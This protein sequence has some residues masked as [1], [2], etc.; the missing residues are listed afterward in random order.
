MTQPTTPTA[1]PSGG[2]SSAVVKVLLI[3]FA[4]VILF[5]LA[6]LGSC[7]YLGYRAKKKADEIR[8][9]YKSGDLERIAGA[10]GVGPAKDSSASSTSHSAKLAFPAWTPSA[11]SA[12][13]KVPL[14]AGLTAVSAVAQFGGDYQSVLR[15][16]KV[17]PDSV[18]LSLRADNVPNPL[19]GL[20]KIAGDKAPPE[21]GSVSAQRTVRREDMRTAHELQEWFS[22]N[23]PDVFPGTTAFS[24]SQEVFAELRS[25]GESSFRFGLGGVKGMVGSLVG[26]LEQMT[27]SADPKE[28]AASMGKANCTLK[29]AGEVAFPILLNDRRVSL[30]AMH[31]Q[32]TTEDGTADFYFLDDPENPLNLAFKLGDNGDAVQVISMSYPRV[33]AEEAGAGP[34]PAQI[35]QAP[36]AAD[37]GGEGGGPAGAG[38]DIEKEL[39]Q[40]GQAEVYGIYFD[41][42]SDKMKPE[43]ETVLK[44]IAAALE[45][46]ASWN[47]RVEGHTDN[48]GGDTYNMDLSQRRAAAVK[49]AL[50]TRHGIGESRLDPQ[51]FGATRPKESNDTVAGRARNR[52]VELVRK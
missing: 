6:V 39:A 40:N 48:V 47:L 7:V 49:Q 12:Q 16:N 10:V 30:P 44:E 14:V 15:I 5:M 2:G 34:G 36:P 17:N 19:Q 38:A 43:S 29:R 25:K 32:C 46:N 26:G 28:S 13:V 37:T 1:A 33:P 42:G 18:E 23:H 22:Q 24:V 52:R 51:G 50:V 27:G 8:Q 31:A 4:L 41:F 9:A 11:G 3:F 21:T 35:N 20:A 45:H